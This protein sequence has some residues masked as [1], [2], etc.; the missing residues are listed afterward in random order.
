MSTKTRARAF[1]PFFTTPGLPVASGLG[2]STV[3]GIVRQHGG[4]IDLSSKLGCGTTF[5]IAF[6]ALN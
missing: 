5:S 3:Y 2:L 1:E 4:T 6:P